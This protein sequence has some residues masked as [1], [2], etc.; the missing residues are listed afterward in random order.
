MPVSTCSHFFN[1]PPV[2]SYVRHFRRQLPRPPNHYPTRR[3]LVLEIS[4][5]PM[6]LDFAIGLARRWRGSTLDR[7][8]RQSILSFDPSQRSR[9]RRD[10]YW[11]RH[12]DR[13]SDARPQCHV[14]YRA[15]RSQGTRRQLAIGIPLGL[16]AAKRRCLRS[17][18]RL[19]RALDNFLESFPL[20]AAAILIANVVHL[21][22][23]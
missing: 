20:F 19:G 9:D 17:S 22:P 4:Y 14:R 12:D 11:M 7:R 2:R 8:L 15:N 10:R 16:W 13:T 23:R 6:R 18:W 1:R 5:R 3:F 21:A